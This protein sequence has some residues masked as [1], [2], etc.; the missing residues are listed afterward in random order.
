[1]GIKTFVEYNDAQ[2]DTL[3]QTEGVNAC[4]LNH[5]VE[6]LRMQVKSTRSM[7]RLQCGAVC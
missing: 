1:V 6:F 5:T 7:V 4:V 2:E 3:L